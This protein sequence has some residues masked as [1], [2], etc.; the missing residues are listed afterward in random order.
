MRTHFTINNEPERLM[1]VTDILSQA[2]RLAL[3][4]AIF[5]LVLAVV[6]HALAA[7][8]QIRFD[9]GEV[10]FLGLSESNDPAN[11]ELFDGYRIVTVPCKGSPPAVPRYY[12]FAL[13]MPNALE[14]DLLDDSAD[15]I[16][17]HWDI[18]SAALVA[19]GLYDRPRVDAYRDQVAAI[20]RQVPSQEKD[21]LVQSI[22]ETLHGRL[23]TGKYDVAC[24]NLAQSID[25]GDFNCVSATVLFHAMA[26]HAGLDVCGLE[27]RGHALS[28]VRYNQQVIDLETTCAEWF[29]LSESERKRSQAASNIGYDTAYIAARRQMPQTVDQSL[30]ANRSPDAGKLA[31]RSASLDPADLPP[32]LPPN[33]SPGSFREIT[34]V[35]LIATI[36]YNRGVDELTAGHFSTASVANIKALQLDPH[37]ENAWRNLMATFNNWAIARASEGDYVSAAQLLD[38][39]RFIDDGYELFRAN[40]VH[41]YYHW[42]VDVADNRD[43][44]KALT[45]L[46]MAED[47][48]P[49][50]ANLRFL[51]YTIRRKMANDSISRQDD[52]KAYEQ[53]DLAAEVAPNGINAVE[54][55]VMDVLQHIRR[56]MDGNKLSRAIWLI[57]REFERHATAT[58]SSPVQS[59]A[60]PDMRKQSRPNAEPSQL[61]DAPPATAGTRPYIAARP[62]N[63]QSQATQKNT[64]HRQSVK[65]EL[66]EQMQ[67]LRANA[68]VTWANESLKQREYPEAVRRLT[69]G[70]PAQDRFSNEQ[71]TLL[72]QTYTDWAAALRSENRHA[73]AQTVHKLAAD[74]PFLAK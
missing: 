46:Q 40:Q 17:Q 47:R 20:V 4:L 64:S 30:K 55:E 34:D 31:V 62:T 65:P 36:Y 49:N 12:C 29:N 73:E 37:N 50:Q 22:F 57:D 14:Y 18:V 43:F 13:A 38:E 28:R 74:S 35:Q 71:L 61:S 19:E 42:V 23:L 9:G 26:Q 44:D 51:N 66:L 6:P 52:R 24:T 3:R 10:L 33:E 39:G 70:E 45:L 16:W 63:E 69:I 68:V 60:Q 41:T 1:P 7:P 48:L 67:T 21:R 5:A 72:R 11:Q 54:A 15:G 58:A 56:L 25:T 8:P 53:F 27:M 2:G 59:V 32:T